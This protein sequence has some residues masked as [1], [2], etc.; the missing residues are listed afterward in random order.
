ML[1]QDP[2]NGLQYSVAGL[3]LASWSSQTLLPFLLKMAQQNPVAAP[4]IWTH[5]RRGAIPAD[6]NGMVCTSKVF[7][8]P[9]YFWS[10]DVRS[11]QL[12]PEYLM[13]VH[14]G[15]LRAASDLR[16]ELDQ[17]DVA[18]LHNHQG[19]FQMHIPTSSTHHKAIVTSVQMKDKPA[20][21]IAEHSLTKLHSVLGSSP[22]FCRGSAVGT[23]QSSMESSLHFL[24]NQVRASPD[25]CMK[26]TVRSVVSMLLLVTNP[27]ATRM[28]EA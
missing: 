28:A 17:A 18:W 8:D 19:R 3:Q 24:L 22:R 5:P 25:S 16:L 23:Y 26:C 4:V 1:Q 21:E 11:K 15:I 7:S 27:K 12:V 20:H 10:T 2:I 14:A 9:Q 6:G 13:S